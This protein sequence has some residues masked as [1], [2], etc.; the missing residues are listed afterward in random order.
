MP[1]Q[2]VQMGN[3]DLKMAWSNPNMFGTSLLIL[4]LDTY[5]MDAL[6][7]R[8][9]T[10]Q[11]EIEQ[12]NG[13]EVSAGNYDRLMTAIHIV[14]GNSFFKSVPDF[15]R[16][17]VVLS[18]HHPTPDLMMLPDCADLAWGITEG[19]LINPPTQDNEEPFAEEILGYISEALD[20]E[21]ILNP[22]DVLRIA[23]KGQELQAKANYSWS[24]DP[25]MFSA[26]T[27]S[28][29]GKTDD[30]NTMVLGRMVALI[31]QLGSLP[32]RVG[33]TKKMAEKL[34]SKL[35][36]TAAPQPLPQ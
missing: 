23:D 6:Q 13:I 4:F 36:K 14:S 31:T 8:P 22:P 12:D 15:V 16:A 34:L 27:K 17:C 35:P 2:F 26:I 32:V 28:E 10:I 3:Q 25:E 7:W 29:S 33:E 24:D 9:T 19:L 1:N 20:S 30:I 11:I 18:G 5:G 21:G